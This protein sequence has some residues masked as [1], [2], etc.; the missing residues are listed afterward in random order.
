MCFDNNPQFLAVTMVAI[1]L[2]SSV[3]VLQ[4]SKSIFT[5]GEK[6]LSSLPYS[7]VCLEQFN[8]KNT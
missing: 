2:N 1:S 4:C 8:D 5:K 3:S 7:S 6:N